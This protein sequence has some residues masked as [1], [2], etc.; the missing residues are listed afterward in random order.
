MDKLAGRKKHGYYVANNKL[1]ISP[2]GMFTFTLLSF[3]P[4]IIRNTIVP[5]ATRFSREMKNIVPSL[6]RGVA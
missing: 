6:V 3:V 5:M 2:S 4:P 1:V